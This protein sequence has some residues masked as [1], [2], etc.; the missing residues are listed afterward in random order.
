MLPAVRLLLGLL[1]PAL[2]AVLSSAHPAV[3]AGPYAGYILPREASLVVDTAEEAVVTAELRS[4]DDPDA[5]QSRTVITDA[6]NGFRA[7]FLFSGLRADTRY[8]YGIS[9]N[10]EPPTEALRGAFRTPPPP[11]EVAPER[12]L[13]VAFVGARHPAAPGVPPEQN[14]LPALAD[15]RVDGV[16]WTGGQQPVDRQSTP[17]ADGLRRQY[18]TLFEEPDLAP[19][20][21]NTAQYSVWSRYEAGHPRSGN[22]W[23]HRAGATDAFCKSLPR[24]VCGHPG[25]GGTA[26][27]VRLGPAEFF[28]LDAVSF[29]RSAGTGAP[30][31]FGET[32]LAWLLDALEASDAPFRVVIA[33]RSLLTPVDQGHTWQFAR[34]E[35]NGFLEALRAAAVPG[36]FLVTGAA[37]E[38]EMTR[39]SRTGAYPLHELSLGPVRSGGAPETSRPALNYDR[40]P[41]T[42]V[43]TAHFAVAEFGSDRG[44]PSMRITV[45]DAAGESLWRDTFRASELRQREASQRSTP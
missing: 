39:I 27:Q 34:A 10:G 13:R 1:L 4:P 31:A 20:L 38:G 11:L 37:P 9:I 44:E 19:L 30:A 14:A 8:T 15:S 6:D 12:P 28:F 41:G 24:T 35:R 3:V 33:G 17:T 23:I 45:I 25:F 36:V 7:I 43:D 21:R 26:S 40:M 16:I 22:R 5:R 29:H 32:Q 2:P 42:R 18:R